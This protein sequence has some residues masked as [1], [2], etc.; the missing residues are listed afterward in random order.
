M[1]IASPQIAAFHQAFLESAAQGISLFCA[2][3]DNGAYDINVGFNDPVA[4]VLTVDV[5]ASDPAITAG[6]RHDHAADADASPIRRRVRRPR[7]RSRAGLGLGLHCRTTSWSSSARR[8][9]TRL[10]PAGGGGGVELLWRRPAYQSRHPWASGAREHGQ[11]VIFDDGSGAGPQ[12]LLDLPA[13]LCRPQCARRLAQR[14]SIHRL[15]R[16]LE[17]PMADLIDG[18]RRHQLRRAATEW[19]HR[20]ARRSDAW[21]ARALESD[22]VSIEERLPPQSA[23]PFVDISAATTGSITASPA[24]SRARVLACST[25]RSS[26]RPSWTTAGRCADRGDTVSVRV[27]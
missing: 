11:R 9:R 2:S 22:A 4:N 7:R 24:T 15:H 26:P 27:S 5:P 6:R 23:S 21:P 3:G 16:L 19:H 18:L 10:F 14:R 13:R 1:R 12:D 20:A 17:R 25:W 8:I